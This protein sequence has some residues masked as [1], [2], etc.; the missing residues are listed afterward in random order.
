MD[1]IRTRVVSPPTP[2]SI[3]RA[4][5]AMWLERF[6]HGFCPSCEPTRL[7][8][9]QDYC[10]N[11]DCRFSAFGSPSPIPGDPRR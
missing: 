6:Q 5:T 11:P 4:K 10:P 7:L 8:N 2:D 1:V 3:E 9:D